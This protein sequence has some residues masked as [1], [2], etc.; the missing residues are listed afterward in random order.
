MNSHGEPETPAEDPESP[1]WPEDAPMRVPYPEAY[2]SMIWKPTAVC[3]DGEYFVSYGDDM[4]E[5]F[6]G[7][8]PRIREDEASLLLDLLSR[9]FVYDAA[10]RL[11]L[12]EIAAHPWFRFYHSKEVIHAGWESFPLEERKERQGGGVMEENQTGAAL[13]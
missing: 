9:I 3:I 1:R 4:E 10:N 7:A 5:A 12:E 2:G 6:L 11:G 13:Y 8:F